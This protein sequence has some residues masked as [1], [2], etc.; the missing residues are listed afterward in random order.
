M[1]TIFRCPKC[2]SVDLEQTNG[3][4]FRRWRC[5]K[6]AH[7]WATTGSLESLG[8][9]P[10]PAKKISPELRA[11]IVATTLPAEEI[12]LKHG[13]RMGQVVRLIGREPL[14]SCFTCIHWN[15]QYDLRC[16][17]DHPEA[18]NHPRYGCG[19]FSPNTSRAHSK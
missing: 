10:T 18:Q 2:K 16:D 12:A 19:A 15:Q 5:V 6:C 4:K 13:L 11:E 9:K 14:E 3:G 7:R 1:K 8:Y 17:L